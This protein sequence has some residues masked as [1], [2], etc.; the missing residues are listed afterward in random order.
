MKQETK[1]QIID[2]F[3]TH[4]KDTGSPEIQI[5]LLTKEIKDLLEHLKQHPKDVHSKR[6][7]LKKVAERKKL[8]RYLK[9]NNEKRYT[10]LIKKLELRK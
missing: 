3:K 2:K 5:A 1:Q 4:K 6:G 10:T 8:L 9:T 7:L